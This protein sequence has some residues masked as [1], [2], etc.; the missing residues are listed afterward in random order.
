MSSLESELLKYHRQLDDTVEKAK[1]QLR[2]AKENAK[3]FNKINRMILGSEEELQKSLINKK[4]ELKSLKS[5][6]RKNHN[7]ES[8]RNKV[9]ENVAQLQKLHSE[10][11]LL[12]SIQKTLNNQYDRIETLFSENGSGSSGVSRNPVEK[13]TVEEAESTSTVVKKVQQTLMG[14][15]N[16]GYEKVQGFLTPKEKREDPKKESGNQAREIDQCPC[17]ETL[18]TMEELEEAVHKERREDQCASPYKETQATKEKSYNNLKSRKPDPFD[19]TPELNADGSVKE[20]VITPTRRDSAHRLH[21][22]CQKCSETK[23]QT[24]HEA[25]LA[26]PETGCSSKGPAGSDDE[27]GCR[28]LLKRFRESLESNP[29]HGLHCPCDSCLYPYNAAF[30]KS[31]QKHTLK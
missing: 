15:V 5:A 17:K 21:C 10:W 31:S 27:C 26:V 12:N 14:A 11:T 6:A 9:V 28:S 30:F 13:E 1:C 18:T 25:P 19:V 20:P 16:K 2:H 3:R 4:K 7:H 22:A 24:T 29:N 8:T 23:E